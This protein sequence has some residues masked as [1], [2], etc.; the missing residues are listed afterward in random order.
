[1]QCVNFQLNSAAR[2]LRNIAVYRPGKRD[3]L[4]T[5]LARASVSVLLMTS[6]EIQLS[7]LYS[8]DTEDL[9]DAAVHFEHKNLKSRH[10][11]TLLY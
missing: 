11:I 7:S 9:I 5:E 4:S 8:S 6:I 1:M 3:S 2:T 10:L